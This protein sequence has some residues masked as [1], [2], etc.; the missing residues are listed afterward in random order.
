MRTEREML[1][2]DLQRM[3]GHGFEATVCAVCFIGIVV[4][5]VLAI[6]QQMYS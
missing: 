5:V 6:L 4:L 2:R 1:A 3:R